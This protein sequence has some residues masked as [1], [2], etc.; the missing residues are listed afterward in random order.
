VWFGT[1]YVSA[2]ERVLSGDAEA[3]AVSYY[4]LD[5]EQHLRPEQRARLKCIATQGP[6]PTHVI[7]VRAGLGPQAR[8]ALRQA[9]TKLN[10]PAHQALRDRVFTSKLVTVDAAAHLDPL[11]AALELAQSIR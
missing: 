5:G 3:A 2:I 7:A 9:L 11:R 4:V 10:E 8:D 1:G 6:V